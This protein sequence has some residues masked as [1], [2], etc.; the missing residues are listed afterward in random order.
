MVRLMGPI[1]V[2]VKIAMGRIVMRKM[3]M[4]MI[5]MLLSGIWAP[6]VLLLIMSRW[7]ILLDSFEQLM[8]LLTKL[9]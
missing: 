4:V 8:Y 6:V 1:R 7:Q 5:P 3:M 9:L 2:K